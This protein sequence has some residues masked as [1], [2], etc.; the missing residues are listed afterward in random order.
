MNA[1]S[2]NPLVSV[3]V[4]PR[5]VCPSLAT[6]SPASATTA[7]GAAVVAGG[8]VVAGAAAGV[9]AT[10]GGSAS[11][12][13]QPASRATPATA[14]ARRVERWFIGGG[15]L[16]C[17]PTT[18]VPVIEVWMAQKNVYDPAAAGATN[19]TDSPGPIVPVSNVPSLDVT[20]W[21]AESSLW[22]VTVSPGPRP[23][24]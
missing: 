24:R 10:A 7:E 2:V 23:P 12:W 11:D 21:A 4:S 15:V 13:L 16:S 6:T 3:R 22:T 18:K 5:S 14:M 8:A 20:V 19:V 1:Y 9:A 17:Q